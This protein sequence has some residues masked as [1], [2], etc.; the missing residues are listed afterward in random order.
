[1]RIID[2]NLLIH[3]VNQDSADHE[4]TGEWREN[5]LSGT[6]AAGFARAV[7][8]GIMDRTF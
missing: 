1:M 2:P 4:K 5:S 7:A 6:E 3:A 8:L